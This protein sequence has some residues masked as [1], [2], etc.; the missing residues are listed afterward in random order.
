MP[1]NVGKW[2]GNIKL[3]GNWCKSEINIVAKNKDGIILGECKYKNKLVGLKELEL[4][5]LKANFVSN[6]NK[7]IYY[8]LVSHSGFTDELLSIK[9]D[10]LILINGFKMLL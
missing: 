6:E 5:K 9:D 8:L 10:N 7:N 2:W 1:S 3:N 4:L